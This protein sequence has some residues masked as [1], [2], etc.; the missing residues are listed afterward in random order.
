MRRFFYAAIAV[1][2]FLGA[3]AVTPKDAPQGAYEVT[4]AFATSLKA[5]NVYAAMPRCS[6]TQKDP[7]SRQEI[8]V[9]IASAARK[10]DQ[11]VKG[12]QVVANDTTTTDANR[13]KAVAAAN[14]AVTSLNRV[15]PH[16]GQ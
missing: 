2:A 13:Q 12:A 16:G 10:A 11:A 4:A 14:D 8:V 9:Q 15:I 6:A 5:A 1:T 3:C 7:C